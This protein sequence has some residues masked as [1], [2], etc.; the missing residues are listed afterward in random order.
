MWII[1]KI[2]NLPLDSSSSITPGP[3]PF[4][5]SLR[6]G[7]FFPGSLAA[8]LGFPQGSVQGPLLLPSLLAWTSGPRKAF[9]SPSSCDMLA[10]FSS[11]PAGPCFSQAGVHFF[12]CM[13]QAPRHYGVSHSHCPREEGLPL[14]DL[15]CGP[16]QSNRVRSPMHKAILRLLCMRLKLITHVFLLAFLLTQISPFPKQIKGYHAKA[17]TR[18]R[19]RIKKEIDVLYKGFGHFEEQRKKRVRQF[20]IKR[21]RVRVRLSFFYKEEEERQSKKKRGNRKRVRDL[22]KRKKE[23]KRV[24]KL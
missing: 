8:S 15:S 6:G 24:G 10:R 9:F 5:A 19:R 17:S 3:L 2:T 14:A 22:K 20:G 11:P 7:P 18:N 12:S 23:E 13:Q 16:E 1:H 4:F 21:V